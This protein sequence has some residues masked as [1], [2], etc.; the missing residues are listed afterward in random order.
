MYN[1]K[2]FLYFYSIDRILRYN[3]S[4]RSLKNCLSFHLPYPKYEGHFLQNE[5]H[6]LDHLKLHFQFWLKEFYRL[7]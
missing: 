4:G 6:F 2:S 1:P 3:K 7:K 5:V